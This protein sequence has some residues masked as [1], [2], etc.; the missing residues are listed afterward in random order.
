MKPKV[1]HFESIPACAIGP[2]APGASIRVLISDEADDAPVYAMR[3]IEIEPGGHSPDH[4]HPW[5]HENYVLEG[6]GEV[7]MGERVLPIGPGSVILVPP[8]VR[9]QY[10][11]T[12]SYLLRFLCSIPVAR[13]RPA[14]G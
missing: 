12:G 6:E 4:A 13:L 2:E 11:N 10:R 14:A 1:V 3:M 8:E 9:H 5:E 7:K